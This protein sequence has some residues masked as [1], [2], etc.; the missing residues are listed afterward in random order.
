MYTCAY[1]DIIKIYASSMGYYVVKFFI[2]LLQYNKTT[3]LMI[4]YLNQDKFLSKVNIK[5]VSKIP[6][7]VIGDQ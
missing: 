1:G 2:S 7:V 5:E 3:K 4:T 6:N